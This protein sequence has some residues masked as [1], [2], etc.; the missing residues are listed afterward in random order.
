MK[1]I[2]I[3]C[4]TIC[5]N[6]FATLGHL[7]IKCQSNGGDF[8]GLKGMTKYV[9]CVDCIKLVTSVITCL[10]VPILKIPE[11]SICQEDLHL[12]PMLT[13]FVIFMNSRD[14]Q[15]IFKV[16]KFS[17]IIL[18][19]K[20]TYSQPSEQLFPKRWSLSNPNRTKSNLNTHKVRRHRN[21]VTK[22]GNREPQQNYRLGTVS[23]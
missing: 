15:T 10:N 4:P 23:N 2:L 19:T 5:L 21:S 3:F 18:K 22:T 9:S 13:F 1:I 17:K 6:L 20:R 16:A 12:D 11:R 7:I 8:W 14:T